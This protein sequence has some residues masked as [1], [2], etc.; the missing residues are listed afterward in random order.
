MSLRTREPYTEKLLA[1]LTTLEPMFTMT[2]GAARELFGFNDLR[3]H[4]RMRAHLRAKMKRDQMRTKRAFRNLIKADFVTSVKGRKDSY[5]VTPKGWIVYALRYA[6][7]MKIK[8]MEGSD[9]KGYL[10][11]FD[12]PEKYRNFRD[13]FRRVLYSLGFHQLQR[14]VFVVHDRKAFEFA[15]R[16]VANC[17][18]QDRVKF[19]I[20]E[21]VF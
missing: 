2:T 9:Q 1:R 13:I 3:K 4:R 7:H 11:I 6:K 20:A 14:S 15:C 19:I 18:L 17:E 12:I 5:T 8:K 10:I 21:K 16:I